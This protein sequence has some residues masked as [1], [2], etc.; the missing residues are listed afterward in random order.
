MLDSVAAFMSGII[1]YAGLFPPARLDLDTAIRNY[2]RYRTDEHAHMVARFVIPAVRLPELERFHDEIFCRSEAPFEFSVLTRSGGHRDAFVEG[3][4]ADLEEIRTFR[5][6]HGERIR[7]DALELRL[8]PDLAEQATEPELRE[9]LDAVGDRVERSIPGGAQL[10]FE[11][12]LPESWPGRT[13]LVVD[14]IAAKH[15]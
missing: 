3:V 10:F 5:E 12:G 1:D 11:A 8:S 4:E 15:A 2:A 7:V 6:R 13:A 9:S 14:A